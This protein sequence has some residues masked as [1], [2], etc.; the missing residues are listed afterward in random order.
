MLSLGANIKRTTYF[1]D[2]ALPLL[3]ELY[4]LA[5]YLTMAPLDAVAMVLDAYE[6]ASQL[7]DGSISEAKFD[8]WMIGILI[9]ESERYINGG[10]KKTDEKYE[11]DEETAVKNKLNMFGSKSKEV[12]HILKDLLPRERL[13]LSLSE[14]SGFKYREIANLTCQDEGTVAT[15]L[16]RIRKKLYAHFQA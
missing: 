4:S 10:A 16:N 6:N 12:V 11:V 9:A 15:Q 5:F 13:V 3:D 8:D 14:I 1:D 7:F 2:L